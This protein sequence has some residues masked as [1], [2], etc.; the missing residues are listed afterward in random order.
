[1]PRPLALRRARLACAG[2]MIAVLATA[3][4]AHAQVVKAEEFA[5]LKAELTRQAAQIERQQVEI[6]ELRAGRSD[7]L[8]RL[9]ATGAGVE[10][11]IRTAALLPDVPNAIS[12]GPRVK[13]VAEGPP[14]PVGERPIEQGRSEISAIPPELGVLTPRGHFVFDPSLEYVR[15]SNNRF[16]FRGVELVPGVQLGVIEVSDAV[17]DTGVA[18]F[19]TRYG[20]TS[21]LEIEARIPYVGRHDRVTTIRQRDDTVARSSE[22]DGQGIGDVEFATRYQLNSGQRGLPVFVA[23]ARVKSPTGQGPYDVNYD[24]FGVPTELATGS[25]FWAVEGG[26]TMLYP[27]DPAIIFASLTYLHNIPRDI[28]KTIGAGANAVLVGRVAPGD[29]IGASLGFGLSLNPRFSVSFG[30]SHSYIFPTDSKL[31]GVDVSSQPL[32]VGSLLMGWSFRLTDRV[33]LNNSF[34]FGVTSDAPDLRVVFRAPYR[35]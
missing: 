9:T 15:T 1:M 5:R 21:R 11:P 26:L 27:S 29:A 16:V 25:G 18:T 2:S 35:F 20:V 12:E 23:N 13:P 30:Y 10:R 19:A 7:E 33:T 17:R 3:S 32:Q 31:S 8:A 6:D 24:A 4:V 14:S 22:P 34:E 28:D